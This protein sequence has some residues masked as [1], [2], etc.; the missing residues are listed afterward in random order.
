[1]LVSCRP[2]VLRGN[3]ATSPQLPLGCM[4]PTPHLRMREASAAQRW[5]RA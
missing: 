3:G 1:M 5:L 4:A 2:K